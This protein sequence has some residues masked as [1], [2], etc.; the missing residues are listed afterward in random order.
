[1]RVDQKLLTA[2]SDPEV[3][4][5]KNELDT[6]DRLSDEVM[7]LSSNKSYKQALVKISQA[8]EISSHSPQLLTL[9]AKLF[10]LEKDVVN[11]RKAIEKL[12]M[13][14]QKVKTKQF[15]FVTGLCCYYEDD[16]VRAISG[17]GE[18]KKELPEAKEWHE[19]AMAMHKACVAGNRFIFDQRILM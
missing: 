8:L 6:V 11:A 13:K 15:H 18:A 19:K 4:K 5:M 12:D 9:Q 10:A 2:E 3:D 16:M 1:M 14:H 17:F 7:S